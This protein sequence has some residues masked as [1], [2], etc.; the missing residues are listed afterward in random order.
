MKLETETASWMKRGAWSERGR[1][2]RATR[3][4]AAFGATDSA[5]A[6][7]VDQFARAG[8][9]R[10]DA[11]SQ[12][13]VALVVTLI[14][15]SIVTFIAIA[16]LAISRRERASLLVAQTAL[17]ARMAA[18]SAQARATSEV[19]ARILA[20]GD[21]WDYDLIV[22][23]NYINTAVT[24][25]ILI[26][27]TLVNYDAVASQ[28]DLLQNIANL[29]YNA[30]APVYVPQG[31]A[32]NFRYYL[33]FNR[34]GMFETNGFIAV[35]DAANVSLGYSNF[36]VGDPEW[37]GV[38]EYPNAPHGPTNRFSSRCCY[39]VMPAGKSLD[40]NFI[41][42]QSKRL[43]AGT[44][45]FLRNQGVGSW[46]INLAALLVDLA[47]NTWT[48]AGYIYNNSPGGFSSGAA[49][50]NAADLVNYRYNNNW[51]NLTSMQTLF[52]ANAVPACNDGF[53]V[54]TDGPV[55][56][57]PGLGGAVNTA[58]LPWPGS[59]NYNSQAA[60][61][62]DIQELFISNRVYQP[63][64][65]NLTNTLGFTDSYRRYAFHRLLAQLGVDSAPPR[66]KLNL[67][68]TNDIASTPGSGS[69]LVP[70][71]PQGF[72]T[73]A[74][75]LM[76]QA[77]IV[78]NIYTVPSLGTNYLFGTNILATSAL[79]LPLLSVTNIGLY[80]TNEYYAEV[81]RLLQLAANIYDATTNTTFPS[82]F[83]P[84]FGASIVGGVTNIYVD[85][86]VEEVSSAWLA[87]TNFDLANPGHVDAL[88]ANSNNVR[89]TS[90]VRGLPV[91]IGAK[92]GY[93]NFN[94]F[95][96]QLTVT[97]T[98]KLEFVKTNALSA[99]PNQTNQMF[100]VGISNLFALEAWNSYAA[101]YPR[102]LQMFVTNVFTYVVTNENGLLLSNSYVVGSNLTLGA[103]AWAGR[104]QQGSFQ[105][106]LFNH[107]VLLPTSA[108]ST[109]Y[110]PAGPYTTNGGFLMVSSNTFD[111]GAGFP[112]PQL[113]LSVTNWLRYALVDTTSDRVVDY[114]NLTN[115]VGGMDIFAALGGQTNAR[116]ANLNA[117]S[118]W[119]TNR[120][121]GAATTNATV[122]T[123]G[124]TNQIAVS[125]STNLAVL[126][127]WRQWSVDTPILREIQRFQQFM[128]SP[129]GAGSNRIAAP[130]IRMQAPFSP[131]RKVVQNLSWEVNDPL[132]HYTTRD[133]SNPTLTN[134]V[135]ISP[136]VA[137][138]LP[139]MSFGLTNRAY[140]PWG[141]AS[142]TYGIRDMFD[143]MLS[144]KDPGIRSSDD[145]D[146]PQQKFANIGWLGRVHRGTPWQTVYLKST[147]ANPTNWFLW[148]N[149]WES[150]PTND[151]KLMDLFTTA[152]ND[153]AARSL[154][155]VNQTN[156][157]AWSALL[158]GVQVAGNNFTALQIEP[159]GVDYTLVRSNLLYIFEGINRQRALKTNF[160]RMSDILAT[161]ELT[162]LSPFLRH[163]PTDTGRNAT[164][165]ATNR[166]FL[167]PLIDQGVTAE[168][169]YEITDAA[170]ERIPQQVLS[171]LTLEDAPRIVIYA[172]GQ[173]L[174]PA[175]RSLVITPGPFYRMCTNYAIAGEF[176]TRTVVRLENLPVRG[177][178]PPPNPPRAV[179]ES[180]K[181][182]PI[183]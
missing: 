163:Y 177:F 5:S 34:N 164:Y 61:F 131:T 41:H 71:T 81:H 145:W 153:N 67:N 39:L 94:E 169:R 172:F 120:L 130:S 55:M 155:S 10:S 135:F 111:R 14:M 29:Q 98:R 42:N 83:R 148:A 117:G 175:E 20:T 89:Q 90:L 54:Y 168:M 108:Y 128:N 115:L 16:F 133:L 4:G 103:S 101:A 100:I 97:A 70:W 25:P 176:A 62:Y 141:F 183:D 125:L 110:P 77:S 9:P 35:R 59:D 68:W 150:H 80:P 17:D 24:S 170:Y 65:L 136:P 6:I 178:P 147:V 157:A 18:E 8:R 159:A 30:R 182:L 76:L 75:N 21:K 15:L 88:V 173:A 60:K 69:Q 73:N 118:F 144:V 139:P 56:F 22:S 95:L 179:V 46:E 112:L 33:D 134:L 23:T 124:I 149:Q 116:S 1:L 85:N 58:T 74:A 40:L 12:R 96:M 72:F 106:P 121:G 91:I 66:G 87:Y 140:R 138:V 104:G 11:R 137:R 79:G 48:P 114:V 51:N 119:L 19:L 126:A 26:G 7:G 49:F 165:M 93:P 180:Y 99:T 143:Y 152:V 122:P 28:N 171:L 37:I 154:L 32:L 127:G 161:P 13:G 158:S 38:L 3:P 109:N 63:F 181:V 166:P 123:M 57:G 162:V 146:F 52:G 2:A 64:F 107:Y 132:V 78:T 174:R 156:Q 167:I 36:F 44:E 84:T 53:D 31:G 151:W 43:A 129:L 27:P 142:E 82:V 102:P 160:T 92:K 105:T 86:Y 50:G 45:G 113:G 47:T